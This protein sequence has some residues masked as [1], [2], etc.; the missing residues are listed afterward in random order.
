YSGICVNKPTQFTNASTSLYGTVNTFNWDFGDNTNFADYSSLPNNEYTYPLQGVKPVRLIVTDTKGCID[1][2]TQDI[3]IVDKPPLKL[4]FKDS[5]IC[6]SD[7]VQLQA[8]GSGNISWTPSVNINN[9]LSATPIVSPPGSTTYYAHLD[10]NGCTNDDSVTIRV[11]DHVDLR[12]MPDTIICQSDTVQL[13]IQSTGLQFAW[14][15]AAQLLDP[16]AANAFAV[17]NKSTRYKVIARIGS[18]SAAEEVM[19]TTVPYPQ[20]YAGIDTVICF[21]SSAQLHGRSNGSSFEWFPTATLSNSQS[22]EPV[23]MPLA[24]TAYILRTYD[25]KGC[26]KPGLDTVFVKMLP[27]MHADAGRDTTIVVNQPLQLHATG[28]V[29]YAWSPPYNLSSADSANPRA[30]FSAPTPGFQYKLVAYNEASCADSAFIRVKVY[31][32]AP[33]VFV[34]NAFTPNGDR[35]NDRLKPIVAG[36]QRLEYF[37]VFNRWGQLVFSSN[38]SEDAGW[39]G[40]LAGKEQAPDAY[41][42]VLKAIDYNGQ[43]FTARG[44]VLLLR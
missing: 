44:T 40:R 6:I 38:S 34:P 14:S 9:A 1:T 26:P 20:A 35:R 15:P 12:A 17:T 41:I 13:R 25:T 27:A 42:W 8:S 19:I 7:K 30:V 32:T 2:V 21:H 29:R 23:A 36:L 28:G 11:T 37:N 5:L 31:N 22:L 16:S 39:N 43:V 4:A 33:S 24:S 3:T 10:D 18:C